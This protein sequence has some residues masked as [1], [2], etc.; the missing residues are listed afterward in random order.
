MQTFEEFWADVNKYQLESCLKYHQ[1]KRYFHEANGCGS[2]GGIN[3]P[4]H[5]LFLSMSPTCHNH[6][7]EWHLA[8]SLTELI[9][10]NQRWRRNMEKVIDQGSANWLMIRLRL[11]WMNRYYTE[12]KMFG[13]NSYAKT[14]GFIK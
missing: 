3:V 10:A 7:L 8:K 4:D 14:R 12:V 1:L 11:R 9:A 13:T 2:K 6:D 5:F